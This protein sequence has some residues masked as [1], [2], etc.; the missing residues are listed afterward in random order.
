MK[1]LVT[2]RLILRALRLEDALDF[3]N[4]CKKPTIGPNA[5][6][7]PHDS[8]EASYKIL[9]IMIK[10]DEVWGVTLKERDQIIGTVGL[11]TLS[12]DNALHNKKEIGY[13][14]DDIHWGK[15][16]MV[17]AV[18][19][20]LDYAFNDIELD[21]VLCGHRIDNIQS[22]RVI[23]KTGFTYTHTEER[24][25]YDGHMVPIMMYQ[26]TK[27]AYKERTTHDNT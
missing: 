3:Y 23:E 24:K 27:K 11:H 18:L 14:L 19:K 17:E 16:Y 6:W 7:K 1:K 20:V 26:I 8:I 25:H 12:F 10:D 21:E 15:G 13:V 4:Y 5:G 22:K 9:K 2:Q